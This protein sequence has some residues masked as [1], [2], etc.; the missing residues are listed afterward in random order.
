MADR[1]AFNP[2][3]LADKCSNRDYPPKLHPLFRALPLKL[4]VGVMRIIFGAG[5]IVLIAAFVREGVCSA[6]QN[7]KQ[8]DRIG[9]IRP[10]F[11]FKPVSCRTV[12]AHQH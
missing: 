2:G 10:A 8:V 9:R 4:N 5:L 1:V 3:M 12:S 11:L 7:A 6:S